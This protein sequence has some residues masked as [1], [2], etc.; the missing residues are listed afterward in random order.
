MPR[1]LAGRPVIIPEGSCSVLALNR[2]PAAD[3]PAVHTRLT[4]ESG[5]VYRSLLLGTV[6]VDER[7]V[8]VPVLV[9]SGTQDRIVSTSLVRKTARHYGVEPKL[10]EGR[11][12]WIMAEPGWQSMVDEVIAWIGSVH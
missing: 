7:K 11:G 9:L 2:L 8:R 5:K 6:R 1:I 10:Y 12:H 3:R 4:H